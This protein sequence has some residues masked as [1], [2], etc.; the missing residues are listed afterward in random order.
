M[1]VHPSVLGQWV[2]VLSVGPSRVAWGYSPRSALGVLLP[3]R[4]W[5]GAAS[6]WSPPHPTFLCQGLCKACRGQMA[7]SSVRGAQGPSRGARHR[8][9][10]DQLLCL[11]DQVKMN[12][13]V[14]SGRLLWGWYLLGPWPG[15]QS[16]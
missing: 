14:G 7:K 11:G 16:P 13:K 15:T 8:P 3:P 5:A 12:R 4:T 2:G 10:K 6:V 9:V 1:S